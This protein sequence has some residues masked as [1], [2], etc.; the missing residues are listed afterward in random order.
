MRR[1]F[2]A[3]AERH[4]AHLRDAIGASENQTM[5]L[6]L[7][8]HLKVAVMSAERVLGGLEA[9]HRARPRA[10]RCV[11]GGHAIRAR[12]HDRGLQPDHDRR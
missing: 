4:A 12:P 10:A 7:A 6:P 9:A 5:R 8:R 3:D 2:K 1:G 11:V